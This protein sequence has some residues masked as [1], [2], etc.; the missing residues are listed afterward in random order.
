MKTLARTCA[1]SVNTPAAVFATLLVLSATPTGAR[2]VSAH[3]R[4]AP[5]KRRVG[6]E[7]LGPGL[8][9]E[10]VAEADH[11]ALQAFHSDG[12]TARGPMTAAVSI[13]SIID[14][15]IAVSVVGGN[16]RNASRSSRSASLM[17]ASKGRMW[18]GNA[19]EP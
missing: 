12:M 1:G 2:V 7:E 13:P 14:T 17:A 18:E 5:H 16:A 11:A 15:P 8:A 19:T 3:L 4:A 9:A 10:M 6:R